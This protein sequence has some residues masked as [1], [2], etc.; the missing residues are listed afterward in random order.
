MLEEWVEIGLVDLEGPAAARGTRE[1]SVQTGARRRTRAEDA[2]IE[3]EDNWRQWLLQEGHDEWP[4]MEANQEAQ[5]V[6]VH[7]QDTQTY[8]A[9][10]Q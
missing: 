8:Q 3:A 6:D 9:E 5:T 10:G 2:R 4:N 7:Q 1:Q